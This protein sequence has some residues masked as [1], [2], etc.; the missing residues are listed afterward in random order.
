MQEST[1]K[2]CDC[3]L[4]KSGIKRSGIILH[5]AKIIKYATTFPYLYER[6][7]WE[8][9]QKARCVVDSISDKLEC[10]PKCKKTIDWNHINLIKECVPFTDI[11]QTYIELSN[12]IKD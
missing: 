7:Q 1:K 10:C 4:T 9:I 11:K 12:F 5:G 8:N 6:R 2:K 3:T